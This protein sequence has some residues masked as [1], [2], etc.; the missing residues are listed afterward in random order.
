MNGVVTDLATPSWLRPTWTPRVGGDAATVADVGEA[1]VLAAITP[2][3]AA[4]GAEIGPGDDAAVLPLAT[5]RAVV[6]TDSMVLDLDWRD[7]WSSAHDVG[8]KVIAQNLADVVAMGARPTGVVVALATEERTR[9]DWLVELTDGM[10]DELRR[11]G[12]GS[13]GGDLSG[14]PAGTVVIT[15]TA[16]GELAP[17][18]PAL[19]RSAARPGQVVVVSDRLGRS[20]AGL[21]VLSG[22]VAWPPRDAGATARRDP[23]PS[24]ADEFP[25]ADADANQALRTC[26]DDRQAP[27]TDGEAASRAAV[28]AGP[29]AA[30]NG[31]AEAVARECVTFH[32]APRPRYAGDEAVSAGIGVA[33]DVSDGLG[34]DAAR[35]AAAS[36]VGIELDRAALERM[37]APLR[38]LLGNRA[39]DCVLASGEEHALLGTCDA[40]AVPP[41]WH[42]IGRVVAPAASTSGRRAA[43]T[44]D[45]VDVVERGWSHYE[46]ARPSS[47]D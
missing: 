34:R 25:Y 18:A 9:V 43:V 17:G 24:V 36:G 38:P 2:H 27:P 11:A 3:L 39:L 1:C 22:E 12:C 15:V 41:G 35:L 37:A 42:V 30:A 7:D 16:L 20:Q 8:V 5:G 6:T 46:R 29:P 13:L 40:D 44:L 28:G 21:L 26:A 14:A 47:S 45:S 31:A 23:G 4:A 10:A 33:M 19:T 32:R